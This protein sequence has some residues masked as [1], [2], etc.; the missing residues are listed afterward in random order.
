VVPFVGAGVSMAVRDRATGQPFF[1]SWRELLERAAARLDKE[2]KAKYG[3]AVRGLLGLDKADEYLEA[4]KRAREGL[5]SSWYDFLKEHL[6]PP[7]QSIDD[8]SLELA[9]SIWGLGSQLVVTTNYD[10]V[11]HWA[12]PQHDDL[13]YWEIEA[14]AEQVEALRRQTQRPVVWHLHGFIDNAANL[15]LTPGGYE[16]L[17]PEAE[18]ARVKYNA[19]LATLRTYLVTHT[20]LFVGFGLEDAHFVRQ[21]IGVHEI[22]RGA[23]GPH[24]ALVRA[25]DEGR[26]R[27]L[28]LPVELLTFEDFG[29]PLVNLLRRMGEVV[30][31]GAAAAEPP[32]APPREAKPAAAP[33]YST[34]NTVFSVPFLS[35]GEQFV[36]RE[37]LLRAVHEQLTRGSRTGL[38]RTAALLGLGGLGKTQLAV[39]YAYR[40]RGEYPNGVIWLNADQDID[41][42]LVELAERAR[43][44]A[45][46][47][48]HK[49]KLEVARKRLKDY[50]DCLIIFDNLESLDAIRKYLP[51]EG[52]EP[53]ILVT[54]R[55]E[56]PNFISVP[57]DPLDDELSLRLLTQE[58]KQEPSGEAERTAAREIVDALGGLPLALELA[59]AYLRNRPVGWVQYRDLLRHDFKSAVPYKFFGG[60][61]TRHDADLY[62][63]LRMSEEAVAGE[64]LL[65]EILD[66]L[67]WSGSAPMGYSLLQSL[68]GTED[69]AALTDAL[70][71]GCALR[72]LQKTPGA[73][74]YTVH[75][76][77]RE[78]RRSSTSLSERREWVDTICRRLSKWFEEARWEF[79]TMLRFEAEIDHLNAWYELASHYASNHV[80][81][82]TWLQAYPPK[83]RGDYK[84]TKRILEK[85]LQLFEQGG[86]KDRE[87]EGNLLGDISA[88]ES[89]LGDYPAGLGYAEKALIIKQKLFGEDGGE[90]AKVLLVF[91][92]IDIKQCLYRCGL[93]YSQEALLALRSRYGNQSDEVSDALIEIGNCYTGLVNYDEAKKNYEAALSMIQ[94]IHGERHPNTVSALANLGEVFRRMTDVNK[95]LEYSFKSLEI[96]RELGMEAHPENS[97]LL[98]NIGLS[99]DML[100]QHELAIEYLEKSLGIEKLHLGDLHPNTVLTAQNLATVLY[101]QG[102]RTDAFNLINEYLGR[103]PK[104]H[105]HYVRMKHELKQFLAQPLRPG[106]RQPS[107]KK[108]GKKKR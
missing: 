44:I 54:S 86:V 30:A 108:R 85:A 12:C 18:G 51:K 61:G 26:V 7:R 28:G 42:Q 35:K 104:N 24:Y 36:G 38:G 75:R 98:N 99:Y 13:S 59:G 39:E 23:A 55:T 62:A 91:S 81:R 31:A 70:G 43:W 69:I 9:R 1:P 101:K 49:F 11:L 71:L 88:I 47:V 40:H 3:N 94:R 90:A 80:C 64:P 68:L 76:L 41:A 82:L 63:T 14:P 74:S 53:H 83:E 60:G 27:A 20:L 105:P 84:E 89:I 48:E 56:Q 96:A 52:A 33:P 106:F 97:P 77:V 46:E 92:Q 93:E 34:E 66:V 29:Q 79:T 5:G 102:R 10:R 45:P 57:L 2:Q 6:N 16:L 32:A 17:Y 107:S 95:S 22:F 72:L 8:E 67:T 103:L 19:A 58:A 4:A 100:G 21:L 37:D 15:I 78:E 50:S 25:A 73:E 65:V 87:L